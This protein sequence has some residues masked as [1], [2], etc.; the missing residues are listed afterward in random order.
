MSSFICEIC[1]T[2]ILDSE[3]GYYTSCPHY[4]LRNKISTIEYN[5]RMDKIIAKGGKVG[6]TLIA[7]LNEA[8]RHTIV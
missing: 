5:K 6:E 2:P 3:R 4:C 7:L 8:F 1:G